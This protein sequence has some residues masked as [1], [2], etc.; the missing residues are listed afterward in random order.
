MDLAAPVTVRVRDHD[1]TMSRLNLL[2][3]DDAVQQTVVAFIRPL[4]KPLLLWAGPDYAAAG[5]Y[6]QAQ[7][8]A[9][10]LVLLGDDIA[11]GLA[12]LV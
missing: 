5:D 2:L 1:L 6:T 4:P 12:Q 9:R 11:A 10:I 8:E 3:V 7:A